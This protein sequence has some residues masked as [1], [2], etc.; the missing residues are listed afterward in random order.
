MSQEDGN[1]WMIQVNGRGIALIIGIFFLF[2]LFLVKPVAGSTYEEKPEWSEE[3]QAYL[4]S[5]VDDLDWVRNNLKSDYILTDDIDVSETEK[6]DNG[7][8]WEPIGG[9]GEEFKGCFDGQG[10]EISDLYVDRPSSEY[11]GLFG[12]IDETGEVK[13]LEVGDV[14]VIGGS[15]VGGL[16]GRLSGTINNS[17]VGGTVKGIHRVGLLAGHNR[18]YVNYSHTVGEVFGEQHVGGLVGYN[19]GG[20]D[21]VGDVEKSY[22]EANVD[23]EERVGGLVGMSASG[24]EIV[25]SYA[26][27]K[28]VGDDYVGGLVGFNFTHIE[29][30]D[31]RVESSY[32]AGKVVGDNEHVGGLIGSSCGSVNDSYWDLEAS[33]ESDSAA[34]NGLMTDKMTE[35]NAAD[36]LRGFDFEGTWVVDSGK[37]VNK[38]Y[39]FLKEKTSNDGENLDDS[40]KSSTDYV[41]YRAGVISLLSLFTWGLF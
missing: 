16:A 12:V 34:G 3:D 13:D 37:E 10:Y 6:W 32:S 33:G 39:P 41:S 23:G 35:E 25:D 2:S 17:Y 40:D 28:V 20:E 11:V 22:S 14:Y 19:I 36:T 18:G 27:G 4:I 26:V 9:K 15:K 21:Y 29:R 30:P 5:D 31:S 24:S 7:R 1:K 38:G 8:G